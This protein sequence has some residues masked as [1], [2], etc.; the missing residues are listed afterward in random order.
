MYG[1]ISMF[2]KAYLTMASGFL[3][4]EGKAGGNRFPIARSSKTRGW[5]F[6]KFVASYAQEEE[7]RKLMALVAFVA[8]MLIGAVAA[9]FDTQVAQAGGVEPKV[10]FQQV[11]SSNPNTI[12]F[13]AEWENLG[14]EI[15]AVR[16]MRYRP[17]RDGGIG[18]LVTVEPGKTRV[19]YVYPRSIFEGEK[20]YLTA[21]LIPSEGQIIYLDGFWF[22]PLGDFYEPNPHI[23]LYIVRKPTE[24]DRTLVT[25]VDFELD[26][27]VKETFV[28]QTYHGVCTPFAG[29][30]RKEGSVSFRFS[31]VGRNWP[32]SNNDYL[33]TVRP[34]IFFGPN[35]AVVWALTE[36]G[37]W[38]RSPEFFIDLD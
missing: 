18:K 2:R 26:P 4:F 21:E 6:D 5:P 3:C 28:C 8:V 31:Y 36:D 23:W 1:I 38:H 12:M 27:R 16:F 11:P 35:R 30:W 37:R 17:D 10:N 19:E 20:V 13:R 33:P 25:R 15:A 32:S 22:G 34:T 14:T 24:K 7:V 29:E 9:P